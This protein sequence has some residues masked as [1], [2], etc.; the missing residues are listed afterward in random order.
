MTRD[1]VLFK[2]QPF[3]AAEFFFLFDFF[4]IKNIE[5]ILPPK[6]GPLLTKKNKKKYTCNVA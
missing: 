5:K 6:I 1:K 4:K 3:T 2:S